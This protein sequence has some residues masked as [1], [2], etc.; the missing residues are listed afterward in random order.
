[1]LAYKVVRYADSIECALDI[2]ADWEIALHIQ[3]SG[4]EVGKDVERYLT[5]L[6]R[7]LGVASQKL[8][9]LA[10]D[11]IAFADVVVQVDNMA[12]AAIRGTQE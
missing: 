5:E 2:P 11:L 9:R 10:L 6:T 1:M 7:H 3:L 4:S 8:R 12:A